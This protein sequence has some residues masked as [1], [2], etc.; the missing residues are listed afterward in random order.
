L[1]FGGVDDEDDCGGGGVEESPFEGTSS[2]GR[3][4]PR[5]KI[6]FGSRCRLAAEYSELP[7]SVTALRYQWLRI[8]PTPW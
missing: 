3:R 8:F 2:R 4:L 6:F 1:A 5:A 7:V